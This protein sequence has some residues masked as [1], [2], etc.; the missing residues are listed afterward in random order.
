VYLRSKEQRVVPRVA[1]LTNEVVLVLEVTSVRSIF[2][3]VELDESLL[4][5][6]TQLFR[7]LA[8]VDRDRTIVIA[9]SPVVFPGS[10]RFLRELQE[11]AVK[12][13]SVHV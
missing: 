11:L 9:V 2:V 10:G 12:V 4:V 1:D 5:Y 7:Q 6:W 8:D 3:E 13:V